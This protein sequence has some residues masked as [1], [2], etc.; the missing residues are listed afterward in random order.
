M[1]SGL[2]HERREKGVWR[3]GR[4]IKYLTSG[5][6]NRLSGNNAVW[7]I[8]QNFLSK[9][10]NEQVRLKK[11]KKEKRKRERETERERERERERQRERETE[12]GR[13][14]MNYVKIYS[15]IS[16]QTKFIQI[17]IKILV[18]VHDTQHFTF[19]EDSEK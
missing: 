17:T 2:S 7:N 9:N 16:W 8:K 12:K 4:V 6:S 19:E 10:Q 14:L 5:Q 3:E 1:S 15:N 13:L 11:R 18:C